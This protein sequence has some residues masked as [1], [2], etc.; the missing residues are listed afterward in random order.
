[1]IFIECFV[2]FAGEGLAGNEAKIIT[3]TSQFQNLFALYNNTTEVLT[4]FDPE[5]PCTF[6]LNCPCS[7][8]A[9]LPVS[10][11]YSIAL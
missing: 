11:N 2:A 9:V 3:A 7:K 10:N 6:H 8:C 1:M 5:N 4:S